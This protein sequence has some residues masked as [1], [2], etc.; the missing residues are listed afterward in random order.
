VAFLNP[1]PGIGGVYGIPLKSPWLACLL[2][3]I[4]RGGLKKSI[5][6]VRKIEKGVVYK[7]VWNYNYPKLGQQKAIIHQMDQKWSSPATFKYF[8]RRKIAE[9]YRVCLA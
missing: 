2:N 7:R 4:G 9:E 6:L 8:A 5:Y 3:L 1:Y